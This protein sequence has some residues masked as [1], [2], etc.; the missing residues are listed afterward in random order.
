MGFHYAPLSLWS[1][2]VGSMSKKRARGPWP[3]ALLPLHKGYVPRDA[4]VLVPGTGA[5]HGEAGVCGVKSCKC[6]LMSVHLQC[7]CG[8]YLDV[9]VSHM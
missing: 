8:M 5:S 7:E 3:C 1:P 9:N 2:Q 6:V 4:C